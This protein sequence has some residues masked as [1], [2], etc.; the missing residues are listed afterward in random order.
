MFSVRTAL[1][2]LRPVLESA[3]LLL[4]VLVALALHALVYAANTVMPLSILLW[5][6][7]LVVEACG[8]VTAVLV[9]ADFV[10]KGCRLV[11]RSFRLFFEEWQRTFRTGDR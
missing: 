6:T 11:V 2:L 4:F 1:S 9:S 5:A 3:S 7:V 10:L 8:L